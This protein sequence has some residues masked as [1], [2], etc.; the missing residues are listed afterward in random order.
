MLILYKLVLHRKRD[1][2]AA[3]SAGIVLQ[4]DEPKHR[5]LQVCYDGSDSFSAKPDSLSVFIEVHKINDNFSVLALSSVKALFSRFTYFAIY[6]KILRELD[7]VLLSGVEPKTSSDALPAEL[8]E[9][10]GS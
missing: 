10:R 9:T 7:R 8:Q 6:R 3:F 5:N 4:I 1:L 2:R